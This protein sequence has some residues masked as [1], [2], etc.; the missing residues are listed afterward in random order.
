MAAPVRIELGA[1]QLAATRG[2]AR[3]F[4]G[5]S[6]AVRGGEVLAV[7]GPNGA[8]KT[9]LLRIVAGLSQPSAGAVVLD[10]RTLHPHD[11]HCRA[12]LAFLGHAPA[13]KDELTAEENVAA[14]AALAGEPADASALRQALVH[15]GLERQ[16]A[17]PARALSQGPRRRVGLAR[18]AA[19]RRK[20]WV[21]DEPATALDTQASAWLADLLVRHASRGGIA[22]VATHQD[23]PLPGTRCATLTLGAA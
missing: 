21:L 18:L 11:P 1:Q 6:F 3:L 5:V 15:A 12:Q 14:L 22:I 20:L 8:G 23:F 19:T 2:D 4:S 16:R 13:L 17:L 7:R 10:G 9:T